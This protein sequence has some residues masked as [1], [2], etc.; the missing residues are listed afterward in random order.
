MKMRANKT[1]A[2][3]LL[4]LS[5]T[6]ITRT[7]PIATA[8]IINDSRKEVVAPIC[9]N[10]PFRFIKKLLITNAVVLTRAIRQI[11]FKRGFI[12]C[13]AVGNAQM[14]IRSPIVSACCIFNTPRC[15]DED[16]INKIY[17]IIPEMNSSAKNIQSEILNHSVN[18]VS[19]PS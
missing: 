15:R 13:K 8:N 5:L 7:D 10:S 11:I 2:I 16:R 6:I 9:G 12:S 1:R 18:S 19:K 4:A 17:R 14:H 3:S